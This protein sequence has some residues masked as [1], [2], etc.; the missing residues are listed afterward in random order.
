MPTI[1]SLYKACELY[2]QQLCDALQDCTL[3]E[4]AHNH[5]HRDLSLAVARDASS[6]FKV[7]A[8]SIRAHQRDDPTRSL[9]LQSEDAEGIRERI[10]KILEDLQESLVSGQ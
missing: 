1:Y 10:R 7:W 5:F 4:A 8:Q 2:Y 9:D 6:R 3:E